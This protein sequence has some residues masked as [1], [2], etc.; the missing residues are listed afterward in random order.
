MTFDSA[1]GGDRWSSRTRPMVAEIGELW[2]ECGV[3]SEYGTLRSVLLHRPGAEL[4]ASIAD[5]QAVQMLAPLDVDRAIDQHDQMAAAYRAVGVEVSLVSPQGEPAPNQMFNADLL[6]MTPEGAIVARPASTV[7]AG[8]ERWVT[9]AL[10]TAGV[11]ILRSV[12]G[13]GLFEGADAMWLDPAT[14]I[15]GRGLRTNDIGARQIAEA[16][17]WMDVETIVVDLPYGSMHLMGMLRIVDADLAIAWP[18]RFVHRGVDALRER[19]YQVAWLPDLA[20]A[21]SKKAF[22]FVTL[23]PRRVLMALDCPVTQA[24][25]ESLGIECVKTDVSELRKAAGAVGCLTG[26][27]HRDLV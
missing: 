17:R 15:V 10:A 5:P 12:S 13:T 27:V 22:N 3:N 7:R 8:E 16:L 14:V 2:P 6:F 26:V 20:E 25:Y 11:P 9:Q 18:G 24:F 23:G 4:A 1:Y 21:D 19:G